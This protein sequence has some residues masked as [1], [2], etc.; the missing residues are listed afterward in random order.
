MK[1]E[2]VAIWTNRLETLKDYYCFHFG[3][4]PGKIYHNRIK[5][6]KSYFITFESGARLEL[7]TAPGIPANLNDTLEKQHL[8]IIHL[9]FEAG[10]RGEVD[11]MAEALRNEGFRIL[12]GPRI[13]GDG[14]Y[15]FA[16]CDPDGNRLEVTTRNI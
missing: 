8:G 4:V 3:G 16:T 11:E 1:I 14:Y 12:D 5:Q 9:A 2:H 15:E 10:T 7:M 13:T 6:Y